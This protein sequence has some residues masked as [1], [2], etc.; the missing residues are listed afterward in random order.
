MSSILASIVRAALKPFPIDHTV[1]RKC[2][3]SLF[4]P[5]FAEV[6]KD[7]G[8]EVDVED[9]RH[10]LPHKM[11]VWRSKITGEVVPTEERRRIDIVIYVRSELFGLIEIESDLKH[12]RPD[13]VSGGKIVMMYSVF[14]APHAEHIFIHT[15]HWRE[16]QL[17]PFS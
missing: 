6:L 17:R 16:W 13:G 3:E 8:F 5:L 11:P 9:R 7:V 12:L 1:Y 4:K 10:L 2:G 14:R 15:I